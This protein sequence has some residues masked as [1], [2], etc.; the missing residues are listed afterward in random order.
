M[1]VTSA[2]TGHGHKSI[3]DSLTEQFVNYPD[4]Q[5]E[6]V[7]G[8]ALIGRA[9]VSSAKMYGPITRNVQDLWKFTY[10]MTQQSSEV[11]ASLL[12]TLIH[13]RLMRKL[14]EFQPD[15][16]IC[17]HAMFNGSVL[18]VLEEY[19]LDI[20]QI[21]LQADI[22]DIH[23]NWCD[24][25]NLMTLCPTK[26]AFEASL[27]N[28]MPEEKL[29]LCGF[30]SRKQFV[31]AARGYER[32]EYDGQRPLNCLIMSGGEGSGNLRRYAVEML[33]QFNCNVTI[34]CGRNQR[35]KIALEELLLPRYGDRIKIE[36]FVKNVQDYMLQS[37]LLIARGSPNTL[38]E[39]IVCNVPILVTGAL[40]GQEANNPAFIMQHGLGMACK[41]IDSVKPIVGALL[42][43]RGKRLKEIRDA[44]KAFRDF[45]I[46]KNIA[47]YIYEMTEPTENEI[48]QFDLKFPLKK[49]AR[50]ALQIAR[51]PKQKIFRP[52]SSK[53]DDE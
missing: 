26:E 3:T 14:V 47:E 38:F 49:H 39:A 34:V 1:I 42:A 51:E 32:K 43:E 9:G 5:V 10:V 24:P 4:V 31:D 46:A 28:G 50:F 27:K 44:Q 41:T 53:V 16:I 19:A 37:D 45:D 12:G 36:G 23:P 20:P 7:E 15:I 30:P 33:N 13:D 40:P 21:T 8:F 22:V 35:L 48:P 11:I 18:N 6:V 25:R 2:Y 17:V 52:P 29:A